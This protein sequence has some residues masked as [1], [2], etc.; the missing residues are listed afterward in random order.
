MTDID[1]HLD[2]HPDA[3]ATYLA[4][5]KVTD[6]NAAAMELFETDDLAALN[7]FP[8]IVDRVRFTS[9]V[10][11]IIADLATG[12]IAS[13]QLEATVRTLRGNQRHVLAHTTVVPGFETTLS[14]VVTALID[15]TE[16][17]QAE[18]ALRA[19][20][21]R[22][23]FLSEHDNLTGLFNTRYLY[24]KLGTL[25]AADG[26]PCSVIFMDLD[27]FKEVVD[28]YGHLDG[29]RAIH[30]VAQVIQSCIAEP[31]FA[32]AYAG[33]EFVIVLPGWSTSQA[34]ATAR[35]L[36]GRIGARTFLTDVGHTVRLSVSLGVATYPDDASD[37]EALLAL[38][39]QALFSAKQAGRNRIL[40]AGGAG[41]P[42][43]VASGA[44]GHVP[45]CAA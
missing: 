20:E 12:Q 31:A 34:I 30:E 13:Q 40:A 43:K 26:A 37:M 16:R 28:T 25:L 36:Q 21:E 32:V 4:L 15:I 8:Y 45:R 29:S 7:A 19:S 11:S 42:Q 10:R 35:E 17:K 2:A 1:A 9:L 5:V 44:P 33:D 18:A 14:R 39:D 23:R 38:A 22:F 41:V 6:M 3:V 24:E 27:R